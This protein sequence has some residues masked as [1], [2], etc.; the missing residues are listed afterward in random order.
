V[1]ASKTPAIMSQ[2][3]V[4]VKRIQNRIRA[5]RDDVFETKMEI[6]GDCIFH[7]W[8]DRV[9]AHSLVANLP[10]FADD[11][12][13]QHASQAFAP[14]FGPKIEAFH[15]ADFAVQLVKGHASSQLA[16]V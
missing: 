4:L 3:A 14:E 11:I 15:L 8:L 16:F 2:F 1:K 5:I 6:H 9:E 12:F 7:H 10:S 13:C